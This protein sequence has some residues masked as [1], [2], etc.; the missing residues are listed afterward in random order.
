MF[1]TALPITVVSIAINITPLITR[2]GTSTF[3]LE[4]L[5]NMRPIPWTGVHGTRRITT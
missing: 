1:T 4:Y 2:K 5:K 3:C